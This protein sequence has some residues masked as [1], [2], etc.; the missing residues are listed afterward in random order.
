MGY[1]IKT[2]T[3]S[4]QRLEYFKDQIES[5]KRSL[6][7]WKNLAASRGYSDFDIQERCNVIGRHINFYEDAINALE[8][9]KRTKRI[10]S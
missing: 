7:W 9:T 1:K 10:L 6:Y 5:Q 2:L 3:Y 4:E 8:I